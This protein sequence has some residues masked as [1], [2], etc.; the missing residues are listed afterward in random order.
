[1]PK[2]QTRI[3]S[4]SLFVSPVSVTICSK[5]QCKSK[6][7]K[8]GGTS[9]KADKDPERT[10]EAQPRKKFVDDTEHIKSRCQVKTNLDME[11]GLLTRAGRAV[12]Y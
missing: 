2:W 3:S 6:S 5:K 4:S 11:A 12:V 7:K 8:C 1:M 9:A 10:E